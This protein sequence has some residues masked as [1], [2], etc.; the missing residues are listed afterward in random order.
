MNKWLSLGLAIVIVAVGSVFA[1]TVIYQ[2]KQVEHLESIVPADVTYYI[3]SHDPNKKIA[4]FCS[5]QFFQKISQLSIYQ[6]YLKPK[7][8]QMK[9]EIF[10]LQDVF[11]DDSALAIFSL[12]TILVKDE[13]FKFGPLGGFLLLAKLDPKRIKKTVVD[14][15]KYLSKDKTRAIE[16]YKG[17]KIITYTGPKKEGKRGSFTDVARL[18]NT[19]VSSND[20]KAIRKA[21]DLYKQENQN[22]LLND[23]TF[24]EVTANYS[25]DKKDLLLWTYTNYKRYWK[26]LLSSMAGKSLN[27]GDLSIEKGIQFGKYKDFMKNFADISV[28]MFASL[29][30][31]ELREGLVWKGY[32]FFDRTKDKANILDMLASL[33]SETDIVNVIPSDIIF[34]FGFSGN[35]TKWWNYYKQILTVLEDLGPIKGELATQKMPSFE[36]GAVLGFVESF[37]EVNFEKDVLPLLGSNFASVLSGLEDITIDFSQNKGSKKGKND[38]SGFGFGFDKM[39]LVI[40]EFSIILQAKDRLKAEQLKDI[41]TEKIMPKIND[42]IKTQ[43]RLAKEAKAKKAQGDISEQSIPKQ[44][45]ALEQEP[46]EDILEISL[47]NYKGY[48]IDV[49]SIKIDQIKDFEIK[50]SLFV[51]DNYFIFSSSQGAARKTIAMQKGL[52]D[53]LGERLHRE[54]SDDTIVSDYSFIYLLDTAELIKRITGTKMFETI[55]PIAVMA[56]KGKLTG[57]DIDSIIDVLD[58]VSLL[59]NTYKMSEDG[60]GRTRA[61][62]QIEGLQ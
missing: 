56:S 40:P 58:D 43:M 36:P 59:V 49:I 6:E 27:Q 8:E 31:T 18:G 13:N 4:D 23:K 52:Y 28:G 54:L 12:D 34:C 32:Q 15:D 61:Y 30:Y 55:E 47:Q 5:F 46:I 42:F 14:I 20:H 57:E 17:V 11:S 60:I 24:Q 35:A 41:V 7:L 38:T 21:I 3:Y 53:S 51:L 29:G 44:D 33:E 39:P 37:L 19:L 1:F 48:E 10:F 9:E 22:S 16:K 50:L 62:I 26:D 25:Q 45:T 2:P